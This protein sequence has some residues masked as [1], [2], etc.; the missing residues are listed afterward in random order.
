MSIAMG[1]LR[2]TIKF[3]INLQRN[4][5]EADIQSIETIQL[6]QVIQPISVSMSRCISQEVLSHRYIIQSVSQL[7]SP[8][9]VEVTSLQ[10]NESAGK[11]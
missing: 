1:D 2:F 7:V 9:T 4:E 10:A 5:I 3:T 8:Q 6:G 11:F